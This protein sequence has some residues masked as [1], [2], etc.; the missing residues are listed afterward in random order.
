MNGRKRFSRII[1]MGLCLLLLLGPTATLGAN[2]EEGVYTVVSSADAL[3]KAIDSANDGDVILVSGSFVINSQIGSPDKVITLKRANADTSLTTWERSAITIQNIIFDGGDLYV[4]TPF[5]TIVKGSYTVK[6]CI[7]Q[8]CGE[9]ERFGT[10]VGGAVHVQGGEGTFSNCSFLRNSGS[11]G[12]HIAIEL[13]AVVDLYQCTFKGG[14]A[15]TGGAIMVYRDAICIIDSCLIT[16]NKAF[17]Y[18]GGIGNNQSVVQIKNT[19]L[20]NNNC[21]CGGADIGTTVG[22]STD[23]QDT[24]EQLIELFKDDGIIPKGWVCD[25]NFEESVYIPDVDPAIENSLLKLVNCKSNFQ[26]A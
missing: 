11:L 22:A 8:N 12:G 6:N 16:E 23:L 3:S 7:F 17:N 1:L 15:G 5:L 18:G 9:D 19:K 10:A 14:Y 20:F 4:T 24:I 21:E 2:A 13:G 25:Y 26:F